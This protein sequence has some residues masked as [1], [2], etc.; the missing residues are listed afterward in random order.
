MLVNSEGDAPK[1]NKIKVSYDWSE[2]HTI[3]PIYDKI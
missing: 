3:K 2:K 1:S